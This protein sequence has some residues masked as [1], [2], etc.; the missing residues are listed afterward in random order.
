MRSSPAGDP[1]GLDA[2]V[3]PAFWCDARKRRIVGFSP[4]L[5][6]T[7]DLSMHILHRRS[8]RRAG[9]FALLALLMAPLGAAPADE[10]AAVTCPI[11]RFLQ[12]VEVDRGTMAVVGYDQLEEV[13]QLLAPTRL[14]AGVYTVQVTR[15]ADNLYETSDDLFIQTRYCHQY[16]Y[17]QTAFADWNG[18]SG[19]LTFR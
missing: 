11:E 4:L 19:S 13:K 14:R 18:Y 12:E 16:S 9:R 15:R 7:P 6:P 1:A 2:I 10:R 5:I 17:G 3:Q 8:A